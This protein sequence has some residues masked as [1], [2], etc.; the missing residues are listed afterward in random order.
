MGAIR[1]GVRR[2][3]GYR[4]KWW[5]VYASDFTL[6]SKPTR[7]VQALLSHPSLLPTLMRLLRED[8]K[9]SLDLSAAVAAAFYSL[10]CLRQLHRVVGELQVGALLLE[11]CQLEVQRTA[12]RIAHEGPAAAPGP[13]MARMAAA[14]AGQGPP[15]TER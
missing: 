8:G 11:L 6:L 4:S 9:R 5:E 1:E 10:S 15:L 13:L 2:P 12:Q 14:A 7:H 3:A